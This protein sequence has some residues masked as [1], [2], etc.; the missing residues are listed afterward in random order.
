MKGRELLFAKA[1]ARQATL[2]VLAIAREKYPAL[3]DQID[4]TKVTFKQ[5]GRIAAKAHVQH[6]PKEGRFETEVKINVEAYALRPDE[7]LHDTIPHEV[8]HLVC[9]VLGLDRG[10]GYEWERCCIALGGDGERYHNMKL[11]SVRKSKRFLYRNYSGQEIHFK[12]GRHSNLQ[13]GRQT[14][15]TVQRTGALFTKGD[16]ISEVVINPA[17]GAIELEDEE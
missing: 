4:A 14:G 15:Y 8:A 3:K 16:F 1:R 9:L 6:Y 17:V 10:H 5:R 2:D 7:M 12:Q 13:L 11:T